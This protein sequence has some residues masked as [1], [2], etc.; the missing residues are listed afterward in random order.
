MFDY[1]R[2]ADS[3]STCQFSGLGLGLAIVR[4]LVELHGGMV[5]AESQ[6][7]DQGAIFKVTLPT[8]SEPARSRPQRSSSEPHRESLILMLWC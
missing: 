5:G 8:L 4:N 1:F 6:G 3:I 2:Q 7:K